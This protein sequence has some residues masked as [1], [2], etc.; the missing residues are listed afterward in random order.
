[1]DGGF[2]AAYVPRKSSARLQGKKKMKACSPMKKEW[3]LIAA[4]LLAALGTAASANTAAPTIC[5]ALPKAQL[6][7]GNNAAVDVSEPVRTTLGQYMTGPGI[8]L[9][10]LDARIPIQIDA[11]A[12]E[13]N[14]SYVLQTSV[15]QT[16]KAASLF[17]KLAPLASALPMLGG[18][19]GNMGAMMATQV[20]SSAITAGAQQDYA[21][22]MSGAQQSNV[23]AGDTVT[24][25]YT[26]AKVGA[27]EAPKPVALQAKA[28]QDG[29]DVIGPM[30]EQVATAVLTIALAK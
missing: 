23:K 21:A 4:L 28:K 25:E 1:V 20:A 9:V 18:A 16:K 13:K 30:L 2:F 27:A 26:L 5:I 15:V 29:E 11:E 8:Q 22:A 6:G 24:V 10:R 14:C 12:A 3:S 17:K 19:G 7:Q